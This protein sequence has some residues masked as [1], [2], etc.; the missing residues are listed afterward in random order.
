MKAAFH[1]IPMHPDFTQYTVFI[2]EFGLFE[3]LSMPMGISSAPGWFQRFIEVML[4]QFI[5]AKYLSVYPD[6]IILH[7]SDLEEHEQLANAVIDT[8]KQR[9]AVTSLKKSKLAVKEVLKGIAQKIKYFFS[10]FL[11]VFLVCSSFFFI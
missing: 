3:Y 2:C 11:L 6:D 4:H 9:K 1:Q 7:S 5:V 10:S 8:I